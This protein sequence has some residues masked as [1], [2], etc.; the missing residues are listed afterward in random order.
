MGTEESIFSI[1]V[2]KLS[3]YINYF[4][5]E[6][7]GLFG[8]FFE[9]LKDDV[10]VKKTEF[11]KI[12]NDLD[13][14]KVALY[15]ITFNSPKQFET[16]IQSMIE[17]DRDFLDKPKK[18]LLDNST[19]LSTTEE[20]LRLCKEYDFEHIKK[21]NIGITGGRQWTAEHFDETGL[22][23]MLF[24]EDDMFFYSKKNE[25][26]RNGF[27]RYV[28]NLYQKSL[29][30]VNKE[31]FDFL[32][33]NF[34]EF[35]G[36]NSTQWSWYN[37]PQNFRIEHW[38]EKPN[39]PVHGQ[40]PNAPRTKFKH[41]KTH[42]GIPFASGEIYYCNWPQVVTRH[43]NKKMFLETTW[44][45]PFEQTWMSF[46]FQETIKGKINP[47]LLLMTPTEHDRFDFYP[48]ELRKES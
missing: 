34:S 2:Y 4:E 24:F 42:N 11:V 18:F 5:I 47:G 37:V 36:D 30:I 3:E 13:I 8:K 15:V 1:M 9:D 33:L 39:L 20:Y 28:S 46:I 45:H 27:N 22:D 25:V 6:Y 14:D 12:Q 35:Y 23:Y 7:N 40:D 43:G 31:N 21:D 44:A 41:V 10:L 16:L 19:D 29:E 48:R 26:C 38:P 17:Y 32:K